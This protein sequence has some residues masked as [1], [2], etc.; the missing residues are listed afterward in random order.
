VDAL[1]RLASA[2]IGDGVSTANEALNAAPIEDESSV[3][4]GDTGAAAGATTDD[5]GILPA[6]LGGSDRETSTGGADVGGGG[7][8]GD[9]GA[10]AGPAEADSESGSAALGTEALRRNGEESKPSGETQEQD[11]ARRYNR[12]AARFK[13]DCLSDI[14]KLV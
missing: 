1:P 7:G 3:L 13:L 10:V 11:L 5:A 4:R 12:C 6:A 14:P 9:G 2:A 8:R